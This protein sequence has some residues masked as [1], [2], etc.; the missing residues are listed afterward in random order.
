MS[1]ALPI[2]SLPS[3]TTLTDL[4][5]IPIVPYATGATSQ[6]TVKNLK[7][8]II[9]YQKVASKSGIDA[10][11]VESVVLDYEYGV[12]LAK[13][14]PLVAIFERVSGTLT[15]Q[16]SKIKDSSSDLTTAADLSALAATSKR[17]VQ[18]VNT[19]VSVVASGNLSVQTTVGSSV[20]GTFKVT[21]YGLRLP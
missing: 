13:A 4:D 19:G 10:T 7:D 14:I 2:T 17:N 6:V 11:L 12:T 1:S 15:G 9:Q 3:V 21:V 5:E 16:F 8:S 20:P 18:L